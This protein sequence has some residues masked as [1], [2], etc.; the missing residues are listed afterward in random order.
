[1]FCCAK[2]RVMV[3]NHCSA[4]TAELPR[5]ACQLAA[6]FGAC[7]QGGAIP[8]ATERLNQEDGAGHATAEN[9][10]CGHF[11]SEGCTLCCGHFQIARYAASI[12]SEGQLQVFLGS[13]D[14]TV[15]C[16]C[17]LLE[18][19]NRRQVGFDLVTTCQN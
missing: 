10:D 3:A 2:C 16:V 14:R 9:I 5:I 18:T 8:A 1:M 19:T 6:A 12:A 11:V 4:R 7:R 15:L 17:F 13:D